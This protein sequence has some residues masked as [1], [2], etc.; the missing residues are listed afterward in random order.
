MQYLIILLSISK[1]SCLSKLKV[2]MHFHILCQLN[3]E[4]DLRLDPAKLFQ[5]YHL[6]GV[7][8]WRV[9]KLLGNL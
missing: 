3:Q 2:M 1:Q 8:K 5:H 4:N 9:M 7:P 6:L